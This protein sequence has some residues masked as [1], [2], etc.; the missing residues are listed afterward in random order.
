MNLQEKI[1]KFE[2][3]PNWFEISL[4]VDIGDERSEAVL[5]ERLSDTE[6][7]IAS[8]P[9]LVENL[10]ADDVVTLDPDHPA[11]Y[12]LVRRGGNLAVRFFVGEDHAED[13]KVAQEHLDAEFR[14]LGGH[15]DGTMG[16]HG[17]TYTVPL[18]SDFSEIER[19]MQKAKDRFPDSAWW[20]GNVYDESGE[21]LNWWKSPGEA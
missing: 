4:P 21:P 19:V 20:Y 13:M 9:G 6:L 12:R 14:P 2:N 11:G 18:T 10:A 17:L 7:R 5:V 8:S 1:A 15:L 16:S 3:D